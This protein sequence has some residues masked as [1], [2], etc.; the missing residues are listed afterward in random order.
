MPFDWRFRNFK[1]D[2]QPFLNGAVIDTENARNNLVQNAG[3]SM[4]GY[5]PLESTLA[6]QAMEGYKPVVPATQSQLAAG[7]SQAMQGYTPN[8]AGRPSVPNNMHGGNAQPDLEGYGESLQAASDAVAQAQAKEQQI[9]DIESQIATLEKRIADNKAKLSNWTGNA[10]KIAAIE[11]RKIN[12]NDPTSIWRWKQGQDQAMAI[13]KQDLERIEKEKEKTKEEQKQFV[14]N[15]LA[16]TLPTMTIGWGTS[17]EQIQQYKNTLAGLKT[18]VMNNK[19]TDQYNNILEL[20]AQL[21]GQ[22]PK[23]KAQMAMDAMA[24]ATN[25]FDVTK[26][27]GGFGKDPKAYHD[28]LLQQYT[29]ITK[30][31]PEAKYDPEFN[32]AFM[33]ADKLYRKKVK[34]PTV[35]PSGRN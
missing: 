1:R 20:E 24:N 35:R 10:D 22:L 29:A 11:A 9:A 8:G 23:Q 31:F 6:A 14:R 26:D 27:E 16:A 5:T 3:N 34:K 17:P 32:K 30:E 18:E 21:N 2:P 13:R 7:A 19:L 4:E 25:L 33:E 15:K 28:Y 12:V